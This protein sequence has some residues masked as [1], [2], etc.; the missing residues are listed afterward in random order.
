MNI[1]INQTRNT[2]EIAVIHNGKEIRV[3]SY[4]NDGERRQKV[5]Q[6]RE[7]IEG[8]GDGSEARRDRLKSAIDGRLNDY[9]CGMKEGYDDSIFG[10]NEA[11][12]IV[13]KIFE[14]AACPRVATTRL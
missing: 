7:Y 11:W 8:W 13:R 5:L 4:T 14:A 3:W 1:V 12:D 2:G 10:F 6:A 9:L